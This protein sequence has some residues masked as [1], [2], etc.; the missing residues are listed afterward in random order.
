MNDAT[1]WVALGGFFTL[2]GAYQVWRGW[3]T[4]AWTPVQGEITEAFISETEEEEAD[5]NPNTVNPRM[6][7]FYQSRILYK[8]SVRGKDYE[9]DTLQRGLFRI[10]VKFIAQWQA[11]AYERGQHVTAYVS[12]RDAAQAVLK[13]GAPVSAYVLL[14]A[15]IVLMIASR[16]IR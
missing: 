9:G 11:E 14:V 10:P 2:A 1:F 8:Y 12:P 5:T 6:Q 7:S 4:Q 15:G 16:A 3:S 13:R